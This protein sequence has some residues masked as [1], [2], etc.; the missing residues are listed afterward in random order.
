MRK[1]AYLIVVSLLIGCGG[2]GGGGTSGNTNTTGF[3][4]DNFSG[5]SLYLVDVGFYQLGTF[6]PDGTAKASDMM[7]SGT[8]VLQPETV[9]WTVVNGELMVHDPVTGDN[10][11]YVL[12]SNDTA[13]RYFR[14]EKH[15]FN[16][17]VNVVGMFYDQV[18]GLSQAQLFVSNHKTP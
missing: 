6:Y 14:A 15:S 7:A 11:R 1:L 4:T 8:P 13:S 9:S 10:I 2:G 5:K 18:T 12:L 17:I 16:G 3:T